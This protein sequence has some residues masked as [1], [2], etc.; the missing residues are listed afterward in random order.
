MKDLRGKV[1]VVTGAASGLGE[2]MAHR[3][4][5]EGMRLVLA[6]IDAEGLG[7]VGLALDEAGAQVA[8]LQT[9]V[10]KGAQVDALADLAYDRFGAVHV[11]CNNAGVPV[12]GTAW[13]RSVADWSWAIGVNLWGVIHGVNAFVPRMLEQDSEGHIVNTASIAGLTCPP[14]SAPYVATKHAVVG[15]SECLHHDLSLRQSKLKVSVLCPGFVK[16]RIVES[17]RVRPANLKNPTPVEDS[18]A[19]E[20][21]EF[22]TQAVAEGIEPGVVAG[23][24]L[25]AI[26][27]ERFWV[28]THDAYTDLMRKRFEDIVEGRNPP[29]KSLAEVA[30]GE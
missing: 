23:Q 13:E 7:R 28:F 10:S 20:I 8:T 21:G 25:E 14:L 17:E 9:D 12:V 29:T 24:V 15:F 1:A 16:T 5:S 6:D 30:R 11:L 26:G 18:F 22:Y 3:F 27:E 19:K 2:A 4:A